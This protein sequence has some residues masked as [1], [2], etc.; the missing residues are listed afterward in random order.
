[1]G[2]ILTAIVTGAAIGGG[3][4]AVTGGDIGKGVLYGAVGGG[5]SGAL[6]GAAGGAAGGTAGATSQAGMLASQTA[7]FSAAELAAWGGNTAG[8]AFFGGTSAAMEAAQTA[9]FSSSQLAGWGGATAADTAVAASAGASGSL[10]GT[11]T[12]ALSTAGKFFDSN[13]GAINIATGVYGM[14]QAQ[15]LQQQA[16]LAQQQSNQWASSGGQALGVQQLQSFMSDPDP[17]NDPAYKL[18]IQAAQR[19][20]AGYGQNSGAMAVAGA[21]ASTDWY[22]Q[23]MAQLANV[24]GAPGNAVGAAQIG[25]NGQMASNQLM[26]QSLQAI[27]Y[28]IDAW[29]RRQ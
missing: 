15:A 5:V 10:W 28:G 8:S 1:M 3:V 27:G 24:A 17:E 9:G 14:S 26:N 7:G 11:A 23:R 4:A 12:D 18:R 19:A 22:N 13:K 25:L 20:M 6:S 16:L 29:G 21:N 2:S